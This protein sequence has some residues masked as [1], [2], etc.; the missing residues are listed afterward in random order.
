[1]STSSKQNKRLM[2]LRNS[3]LFN[4]DT[5]YPIRSMFEWE[6]ELFRK[7]RLL[8][9]LNRKIRLCKKCKQSGLN[10]P[11]VSSS[12]P[13]YGNPNSPI[14]FIAQS[15]CTQCMSTNIPYTEGSCYF[16]DLALRLAGLLRKDIFLTN[17]VHCHP[18]M[19]RKSSPDEIRHCLP[20]LQAEINIVKPKLLVTLGADACKAIHGSIRTPVDCITYPVKHTA[21][22][23]HGGSA[24]SE[25]WIVNLSLEIEKYV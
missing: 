5:G 6:N 9:K 2:E 1:M 24:G 10:L 19:N 14:M 25:E 11:S 17:V 13:G 18:P 7:A 22:F 15:L 16:L 4:V 8:K 21:A 23:L 12:A 3:P 20:Y